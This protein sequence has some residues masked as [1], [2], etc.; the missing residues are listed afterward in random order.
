[1]VWDLILS[2]IDYKD[3]P[4]EYISM[5]PNDLVITWKGE[6]NTKKELKVEGC[7]IRN[8]NMDLTW[9]IIIETSS[10]KTYIISINYDR[11]V[12]EVCYTKQ[13][14]NIIKEMK[15]LLKDIVRT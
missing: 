1:M 12:V 2:L 5:S 14:N 6:D 10:Q 3:E 9:R 15:E 8:Q 4:K 13:E 7:I 11:I